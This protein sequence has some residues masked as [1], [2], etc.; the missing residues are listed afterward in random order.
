PGHTDDMNLR[1]IKNGAK[2]KE[3]AA[4]SL[5]C[6]M[7][8]ALASGETAVKECWRSLDSESM[9]A[10][11]KYLES[12][13]RRAI[14]EILSAEGQNKGEDEDPISNSQNLVI[15]GLMN[16]YKVSE[17]QFEKKFGVRDGLSKSQFVG[18]CA[19]V[20]ANGQ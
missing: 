1:P 10:T 17:D 20:K 8:D 13:E 2:D 11:W 5:A 16:A 15:K 12:H 3:D 14:K 9:N 18:A 6:R 7:R 19:W 4:R